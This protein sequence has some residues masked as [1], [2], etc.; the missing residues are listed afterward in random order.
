MFVLLV[1]NEMRAWSYRMLRKSIVELFRSMPSAY[2]FE[3]GVDGRPSE[4]DRGKPCSGTT[5]VI[6]GTVTHSVCWVPGEWFWGAVHPLVGPMCRPVPAVRPSR[7]W[8][9]VAVHSIDVE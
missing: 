2:R 8:V 4:G 7:I 1:V 6:T 5:C 3:L 9:C